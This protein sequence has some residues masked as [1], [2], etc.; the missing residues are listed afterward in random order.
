[1]A[2]KVLST[3]KARV[4]GITGSIGKT[5]TKEYAASLL[6]KSFKVLKSE[7]NF[8]NH[9]GLPLS[10]LRLQ[11]THTIA[12][13]E[14]GT[15]APGEISQLIQ[16]APPDIAVITNINPVH[17]EFFNDIEKIAHAKKEI[18]DGLK[19][20][21]TAVFNGD[22]PWVR[23]ISKT[24]KGAKLFF[25][26][27]QDCEIRAS[28]IKRMGIQGL[29]LELFYGDRKDRIH[30]PFFYTSF[31]YNFLAAV[32]VA[33]AFST[34]VEDLLQQI[35]TLRPFPMRGELHRLKNDIILIDD[36]YNSNPVALESVLK[37]LAELP[38][39]RRV[40][41]LG[42]MLEL[43][44]QEVDY[45]I[46]AGKQVKDK[47]WNVLVTVGP[48]SRHMG[49]GALFA[50]MRKDHVFSFSNSEEAAEHIESLLKAGDLVLVKGSRGMKTDKI[51]ER[52]K[53]K[54]T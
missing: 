45:H 53:K 34:P 2:Q 33:Y 21:G 22:D 5:T 12:V 19:P 20:G 24:W 28:D 40:A 41:V 18:L 48:L 35:Q 47:N 26:L 16:I 50:G 15:S 37:D 30:F 29:S 11:E 1:L 6:S 7:G 51:A 27:S 10:I 52:L 9:I 13:F 49:E 44:K 17:L 38:A 25:G 32:G 14:M 39:K 4:V 54:G 3:H 8:N 23:K 43:G 36:S 42:D 31:L 46:Q